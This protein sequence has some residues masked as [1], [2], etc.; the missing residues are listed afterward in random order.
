MHVHERIP[1]KR[2]NCTFAQA[3]AGFEAHLGF[4]VAE[5]SGTSLDKATP[6]QWKAV[7]ET[8]DELYREF[9]LFDRIE[10]LLDYAQELDEPDE[11][12]FKEAYMQAG[13]IAE[14]RGDEDGYHKILDVQTP[15]M[16]MEQRVYGKIFIRLKQN[17]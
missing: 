7:L 12:V 1:Q 10:G 15:I 17:A 6:E 3:K 16:Q 11:N 4:F 13:R 14:R 8:S 2:G 9:T 5:Q